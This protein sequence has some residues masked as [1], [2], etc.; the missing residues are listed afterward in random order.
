MG[1]REVLHEILC[2][3][4][5]T[6]NCYFRPPTGLKMNYPCIR[7]DEVDSSTQF[8]DDRIYRL[9]KRY[10]LI[11]IDSNPDSKI[12][13]KLINTLP[14]LAP[15]REYYGDGLKHFTFTLYY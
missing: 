14:Y 7:Y 3:I 1:K 5:G 13:G 4:L 15:G 9:H 11:V 2:D 10:E 12:P 8:A 6:R